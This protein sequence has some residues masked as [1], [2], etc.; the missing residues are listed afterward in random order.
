VNFENLFLGRPHPSY[1]KLTFSAKAAH[2]EL[3]AKT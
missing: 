1:R 3:T 2:T